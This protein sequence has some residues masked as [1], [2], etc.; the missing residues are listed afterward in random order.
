MMAGAA[1]NLTVYSIVV[2]AFG[3]TSPV[4]MA[5]LMLGTLSGL[6]INFTTARAVLGQRA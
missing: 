5:G 6:L 3:Q 1:V 4:L 2:R